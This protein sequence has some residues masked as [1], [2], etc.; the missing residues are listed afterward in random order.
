MLFQFSVW[1]IYLLIITYFILH[2]FESVHPS[3]LY[4]IVHFKNNNVSTILN[5]TFFCTVLY[6]CWFGKEPMFFLIKIV[7]SSRYHHIP[8]LDSGFS[9]SISLQSS[10]NYHKL[11]SG[12]I[13]KRLNTVNVF[14]NKNMCIFISG[15]VGCM[16][17]TYTSCWHTAWKWH[18]RNWKYF[19]RTLTQC[20]I[21]A[22]VYSYHQVL[23]YHSV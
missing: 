2:S 23:G 19:P 1:H 18:K 15:V 14:S 21:V 7:I 12:I 17:F 16:Q 5:I 20:H 3:L 10:I 4:K 6:T 9:S 22:A 13:F 11:L 8:N